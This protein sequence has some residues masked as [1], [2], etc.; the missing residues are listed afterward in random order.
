MLIA[1]IIFLPSSYLSTTTSVF[2][3][4]LVIC[5]HN[6]GADKLV[7]FAVPNS[8]KC[9]TSVLGL[10][11]SRR[12]YCVADYYKEYGVINLD[13]LLAGYS[14][15]QCMNSACRPKLKVKEAKISLK[16]YRSYMLTEWMYIKSRN[17]RAEEE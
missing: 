11:I 17:R 14:R 10:S 3:L 7:P 12:N 6:M 4:F 8:L 2:V 9:G 1:V 16:H 15:I 13:S 5:S